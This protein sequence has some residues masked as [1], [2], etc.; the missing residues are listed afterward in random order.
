MRRCLLLLSTLTAC[1]PTTYQPPR[2]YQPVSVEKVE[3]T[4]LAP[5][6]RLTVRLTGALAV[7]AGTVRVAL[8][9]GAVDDATAEAFAKG[10]PTAAQKARETP[11]TV[12][13]V[14]GALVVQPIRGVPAGGYTLITTLPARPPHVTALRVEGVPPLPRLH[15]LVGAALPGAP[16][17]YCVAGELPALPATT[18]WLDS[19]GALHQA[20]VHPRVDVPCLEI[21][22]PESEG[23]FL[24][25]PRIGGVALDPAPLVVEDRVPR[26]PAECSEEWTAIVPGLCARIDDDRI[27]FL[28]REPPRAFLGLVGEHAVFSPLAAETRWVVRGLL[29]AQAFAI[30]GVVRGD[31]DHAVDRTLTTA[32]RR[33]HVVVNEVLARPPSGAATQRWIELGNDGADPVD[34]LDLVVLDGVERVPLPSVVLPPGALALVVG[35]GFKAG[36][37]GDQVPAKGTPMVVVPALKLTGDVGVL[38]RDGTLLSKLPHVG[39]TKTASRGR[40]ALDVPD[41][42][43]AAFGWDADGRSTP[44][45]PNRLAP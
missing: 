26:A 29:P 16:V 32:P 21:E 14:P 1:D 22:A 15:P 41:D 17:T 37:A 20:E 5:S 13:P 25:P 24:A 45:R 2:G 10:R 4:D 38:E 42:E 39:T 43:A 27:T 28:G 18:D 35:V 9:A 6:F 31:E 36:L 44:G 40:R 12:V 33:R 8:V 11:V 23:V 3:P 34:L 19:E 7:D 30:R